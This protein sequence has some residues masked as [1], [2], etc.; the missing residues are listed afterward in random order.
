MKDK[1]GFVEPVANLLYK[2]IRCGVVHQGM[3][4][5]GLRYFVDYSRPDKGKIFY[6]GPDDYIYLN[7][8]ELAYAY[9]DA[10]INI[11]QDPEKHVSDYPPPDLAAKNTFDSA[12]GFIQDDIQTYCDSCQNAEDKE[13]EERILRREIEHKPSLSAYTPDMLNLSMDLPP[14]ENS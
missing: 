6:T 12:K 4:K 9:L 14:P 8:T 2:V 7:V 1:M 5:I 3:P 11:E 10:L 13:D